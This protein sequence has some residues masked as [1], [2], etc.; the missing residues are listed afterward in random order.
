MFTPLEET[1]AYRSIFAKGKAEDLQRLLARRFGPLPKV[2]RRPYRRRAHRPVGRLAGRIF[3]APTL[4]DTL[5]GPPPSRRRKPA[6]TPSPLWGRAAV[7]VKNRSVASP[8]AVESALY[9]Y[10]PSPP[11]AAI[12]ASGVQALL[13]G[14]ETQIETFP[15]LNF[16]ALP[17]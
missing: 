9:P 6:K 16:W 15:G 12:A 13:E 1:R 17:Q 3:D 11:G 5:L 4:L 10:T 8:V 14:A 2:G 7:G